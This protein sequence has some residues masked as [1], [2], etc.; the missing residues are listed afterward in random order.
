MHEFC[1]GGR[2]QN[3]RIVGELAARAG[4]CWVVAWAKQAAAYCA[5]KNATVVGGRAVV[6]VQYYYY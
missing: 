3:G 1:C 2:G 5:L 4:C 6:S